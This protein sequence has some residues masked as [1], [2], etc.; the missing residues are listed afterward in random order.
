MA[1]RKRLEMRTQQQS[2]RF[3]LSTMSMLIASLIFF[4]CSY[5]LM[6]Q[7][8]DGEETNSSSSYSAPARSNVNFSFNFAN[9]TLQ[10]GEFLEMFGAN[11]SR[12]IL[13]GHPTIPGA[14]LGTTTA[15]PLI[16]ST[17]G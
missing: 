11:S 9:L 13:R 16:F 6:A 10:N 1:G 5:T 7:Q 2:S 15:D 14:E 12:G 8:K 4:S 3:K 17:G